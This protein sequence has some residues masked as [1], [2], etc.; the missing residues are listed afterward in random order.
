MKRH[1]P[2][3]SQA[4]VSVRISGLSA[5]PGE[6]AA[7]MSRRLAL[8]RPALEHSPER[9]TVDRGRSLAGIR[10][11][12]DD[13]D[14]IRDITTGALFDLLDNMKRG[15]FAIMDAPNSGTT[16]RH[17]Q[18]ACEGFRAWHV[19]YRDGGPEG[20]YAAECDSIS[21]L[22]DVFVS[23]ADGSPDWRTRLDWQPME[24]H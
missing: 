1:N 10:V 15:S 2:W 18:V 20:H 4:T 6:V 5:T 21:A 14:T 12:T 17:I 7:E 13:G 16:D 8:A 22:H 11:H 3:V 19:E 24:F 9:Q 23:W